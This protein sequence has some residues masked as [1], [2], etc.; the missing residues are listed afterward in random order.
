MGKPGDVHSRNCRVGRRGEGQRSSFDG[1]RKLGSALAQEHRELAKRI[2]IDSTHIGGQSGDFKL[3]AQ[4]FLWLGFSAFTKRS[5]Y[6]DYWSGPCL[7]DRVAGD[8]WRI[9]LRQPADDGPVLRQGIQNNVK[10]GYRF[11]GLRE[12]GTG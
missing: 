6:H 12:A 10:C 4:P 3:P 9:G 5:N 2:Q 1:S 11:R 7:M 8:V